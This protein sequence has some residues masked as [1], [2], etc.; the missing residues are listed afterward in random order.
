MELIDFS[1][2]FPSAQ[3]IRDNRYDGVVGYFSEAR[4][5]WM[6]AKPMTGDIVSQYRDAGLV[7][8]C[9]Y[10]YGK[11]DGADWRG[12]FDA[13]VAHARKMQELMR[14]AGIPDGPHAKYGPVDDNPTRWEYENQ[15]RPFFQGWRSVFGPS[16]GAYA[17]TNVI[18]WLAEEGL[19]N[20][21]WQHCWD[22][23]PVAPWEKINP[24]AHI[25]QYEIDKVKVGAIG[26]DRNKTLKADFGQ[27]NFDTE[28]GG[29]WADVRYQWMGPGR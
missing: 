5:N 9:N 7:I 20:Y 17:N 14:V 8:V 3:E 29:D 23:N 18:N 16:S 1:V 15:I 24:R 6:Q 25:I 22:G 10:Q 2:S 12:G 13:G 19:C 27:V 28:N 4:V 11:G 21:F 26:V